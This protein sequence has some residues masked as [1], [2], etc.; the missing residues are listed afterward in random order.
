MTRPQSGDLSEA[1]FRA[2]L[3]REGMKPLGFL[4]YV[5]AVV[6]VLSTGREAVTEFAYIG[7]EPE[8]GCAT[9]ATV[10]DGEHPAQVAKDI[11]QW[12]R[13][14]LTVERVTVEAARAVL[15]ACPHWQFSGRNGSVRKRAGALVA[16]QAVRP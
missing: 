4:G 5:D 13:W 8:C 12:V 10:D 6:R 9:C 16:D 2:A 15:A 7:R 3:E 11:A 14:G 1:Q